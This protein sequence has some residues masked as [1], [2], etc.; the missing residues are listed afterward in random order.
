MSYLFECPECSA[1]RVI[2]SVAVGRRVRCPACEALVEIVLPADS[3]ERPNADNEKRDFAPINPTAEVAESAMQVI[4]G[5]AISSPSKQ[6]DW[7][8]DTSGGD[9]MLGVPV[10]AMADDDEVEESVVVKG[11]TE[12]A[13]MDMTPMIDVTFQLLI[14]FMVTASFTMQKSLPVPAP[15]E[16]QQ[17][18]SA[19]TLQDMQD[20]PDMITVRVDENSTYF[21]SSAAWDD[22][23]ECPSEQELLVKLREAR[24]GDGQG[25]V[26]SKMLVVAH[27]D[28]IHERVVIAIDAGITEGVDEVQL[29]SVENDDAF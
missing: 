28:A 7:Q 19:K 11:K 25:N 8:M 2:A 6:A 27:G 5:V 17:A 1:R 24:Q 21:I 14:F 26:P 9:R 23:L 10:L 12:E 29:L 22:E 13:E 4:S 20:S 3:T 16:S 15:Q 18:A